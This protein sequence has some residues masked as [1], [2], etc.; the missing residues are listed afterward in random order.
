M[1]YSRLHLNDSRQ[2]PQGQDA[3]ALIWMIKV[4]ID[5]SFDRSD[6]RP[7]VF[8]LDGRYSSATTLEKTNLN[9]EIDT[10]VIL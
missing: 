3:H 10:L 7:V 1:M 5:S 2:E 4:R 6:E 9:Q 8:M